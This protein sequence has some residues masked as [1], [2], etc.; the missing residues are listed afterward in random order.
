MLY[1]LVALFATQFAAASVAAAASA[2]VL[3]LTF[4]VAPASR[5]PSVFGTPDQSAV[6]AHCS[7]PVFVV[8]PPLVL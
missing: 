2:V 4:A 8:S 5:L 6:L 7:K 1:L 3:V